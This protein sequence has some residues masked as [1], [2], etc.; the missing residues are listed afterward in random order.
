MGFRSFASEVNARFRERPGQAAWWPSLLKPFDKNIAG[1]DSI[2]FLAAMFVVFSHGANFPLAAYV[3]EK[4]GIW[5]AMVGL[6]NAAFNG[7]AAVMVFFVISG[8]CI[9]YRYASGQPFLIVSFLSR[10]L[11]R[12]A[13]PAAAAMILAYLLGTAAQGA[14]NAV[15]WT[16]YYEMIYY[17]MYPVLRMLFATLTVSGCIAC[18]MIISIAMIAWHW[19]IAYYQEFPLIYG[20]LVPFPAW[21][22]GCLLAEIVAA[23]SIWDGE[24]RIWLWRFVGWTYAAFAQAYFFH[25][26]TRIGM[27]ALTLPFIVYSFFWLNREINHVRSS[28]ASPLLEWAGRWSYSIYL[29][30]SIVLVCL[31]PLGAVMSPALLWIMKLAVIWT[32]SYAFYLTI[33]RPAQQFARSVGR[34]F[35]RQQAF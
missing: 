5:A 30:H 3:P 9:H 8:I 13:I 33:E 31:A 19:S 20:W 21:L 32:G 16:L 27:P 35:A 18:S 4:V 2:R 14:L 12:I 34:R 1:L 25:G 17:A 26:P 7:V 22:V 28:G 15:I 10:R 29:M 6:N 23:R 24:R 11:L